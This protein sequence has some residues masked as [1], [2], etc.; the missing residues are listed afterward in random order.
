MADKMMKI[1]GRGDDGTAKPLMVDDNGRLIPTKQ[2]LGRELEKLGSVGS[3]TPDDVSNF[4]SVTY[5]IGVP[6][7]VTADVSVEGLNSLSSSVIYTPIT[8]VDLKN[9]EVSNTF[10][11]EEAGDN[12]FKMLKIDVSGVLRIRLYVK[13]VTGGEITATFRGEL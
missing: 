13:N 4:N 12:R 2:S 5:F 7:G 11:L 9:L 1:A 10:R 3:S 8:A 6:R